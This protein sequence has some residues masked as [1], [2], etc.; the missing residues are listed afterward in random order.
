[1][2]KKILV[3][4]DG[5][6]ISDS[7]VSL[8]I[9]VGAANHAHLRFI[10]VVEPTKIV[11]AASAPITVL[12]PDIAKAAG[13]EF[14]AEAVARAHDAGIE[15]SSELIEGFAVDKI[16]DMARSFGADVIVMGTHGRGGLMRAVL[17][18]V[19]EGVIRRSQIPVLVTR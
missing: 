9:K 12:D 1:M 13:R 17:G 16:L 15:T 6:S 8:A 3:P 11:E 14:L 4:V 2:F 19:A 7:G 5:S 10:Y 18:S